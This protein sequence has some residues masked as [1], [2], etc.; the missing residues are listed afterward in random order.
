MSF[1]SSRPFMTILFCLLATTLFFRTT[2]G[3]NNNRWIRT[4]N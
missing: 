3:S 1:A 2:C 4:N